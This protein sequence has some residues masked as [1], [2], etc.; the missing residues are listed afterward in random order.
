MFAARV[1]RRTVLLGL[2]PLLTAQAPPRGGPGAGPPRAVIG[3]L[4][5]RGFTMEL[6]IG[7]LSNRD[8]IEAAMRHQLDIV[9]DCG[10]KPEILAMFRQQK[11]TVVRSTGKG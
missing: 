2:V 4:H 10:A 3:E 11:L 6:A 1:A 7:G 5:Y 9:A 8:A